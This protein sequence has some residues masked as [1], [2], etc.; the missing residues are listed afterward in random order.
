MWVG[1]DTWA[2]APALAEVVT[3]EAPHAGRIQIATENPVLL[4]GMTYRDRHVD[5]VRYVLSP[6]RFRAEVLFA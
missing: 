6:E 1:I 2:Q 5:E 3:D 4:P